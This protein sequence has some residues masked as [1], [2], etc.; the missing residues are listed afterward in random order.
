MFQTSSNFYLKK[1]WRK[2]PIISINLWEIEGNLD[3]N[4]VTSLM[5]MLL[6]TKGEE[7]FRMKAIMSIEGKAE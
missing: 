4:K 3:M 6:Q 7:M 1:F 2:S 5:G